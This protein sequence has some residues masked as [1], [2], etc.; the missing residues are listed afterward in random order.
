MIA[1]LLAHIRRLFARLLGVLQHAHVPCRS[2]AHGSDTMSDWREEVLARFDAWLRTLTEADVNAIE[3]EAAEESAAPG[4]ATFYGELVALRHDVRIEAK[5]ARAAGRSLDDVAALFQTGV[6]EHAASME[7][8]ATRI[9]GALP[10]VRREG[11]EAVLRE[12]IDI[13]ESLARNVEAAT[14]CRLPHRPW[15]LKHTRTLEALQHDQATTLDK[16]DDALRRLQVAPLAEPGMAF[17]PAV[18]RAIM[19]VQGSGAAP[20]AVTRVLRQGYRRQDRALQI[21][22][23]EVEKTS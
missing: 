4:L 7:Q 9:R 8:A 11:E 5:T 14:A 22:E 1:R 12:L 21:A 23:V 2:A 10:E 13:R 16:L 6:S 18:M 15:L 3:E 20:G 19:T 17:D